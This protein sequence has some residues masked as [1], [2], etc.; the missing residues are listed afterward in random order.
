MDILLC[1]LE[2]EG[3]VVSADELFR[4]VLAG[5][6][7]R[8]V[9]LC[10][11]TDRS[12]HCARLWATLHPLGRYVS[13]VAGCGYCFVAPIQREPGVAATPATAN[14]HDRPA[15]PPPLERMIGRETVV[16]KLERAIAAGRFVSVVGP[17]GIG[18]DQR[19]RWRLVR[20]WS[21]E[22]AAGDVA[23]VDL[24]TEQ[25]DVNVANAVAAALPAERACAAIADLA[26]RLRSRRLLLILDSSEHVIAHAAALAECV[27]RKPSQVR[28]LRDQ[29]RA[30]ERRE[31][32]HVHRLAALEALA[33][34]YRSCRSRTR[35]RA[36]LPRC[37][38]S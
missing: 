8:A 34:V 19:S 20:G 25:R 35:A 13:N 9:H 26:S 18:Q 36:I 11:F 3:D 12:A 29:P 30:A 10:G 32:E 22:F 37:G 4:R 23:F 17:G 5:R 24:A 27:C 14:G 2:R 21:G 38:C 16:D 31:G 6:Q 7:R 28:I 15:L 33:A 1:L